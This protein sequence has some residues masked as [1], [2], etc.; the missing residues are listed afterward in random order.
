M[1]RQQQMIK[2][3]FTGAGADNKEVIELRDVQR[4]QELDIQDRYNVLEYLVKELIGIKRAQ[5]SY[6]E[7]SASLDSTSTKHHKKSKGHHKAGSIEVHDIDDHHHG[8]KKSNSSPANH[9]HKKRESQ[10]EDISVDSDAD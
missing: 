2:A 5:I 7:A 4:L 1:L 10:V 8:H 3:Q 6:N 9:H